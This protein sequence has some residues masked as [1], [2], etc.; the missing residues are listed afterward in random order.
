MLDFFAHLWFWLLAS[1]STGMLAG[2]L[3]RSAPR[4]GSVARWLIWSALAFAVGLVVAGLGVLQGAAGAN[5]ESALGCFSAFLA[6]AAA[7][8]C[9]AHHTLRGHEGWAIGL[10]PAA[11]IWLAATQFGAPAFERDLTRRVGEVAARNGVDASDIKVAG[12]DLS[13]PAKFASNAR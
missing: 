5:L 13:A 9:A 1:F 12:R 6:G 3:T 2:A 4:R 8:A 11:L 7:G 10:L